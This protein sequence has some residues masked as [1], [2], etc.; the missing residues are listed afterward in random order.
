[1]GI[2]PTTTVYETIAYPLSYEVILFITTTIFLTNPI[3]E[4]FNVVGEARISLTLSKF[5]VYIR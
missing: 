4:C 1:M 2:E 5:T 3:W